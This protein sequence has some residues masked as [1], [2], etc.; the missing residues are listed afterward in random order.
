MRDILYLNAEDLEGLGLGLRRSVDI[1]EEAFRLKADGGAQMPPKIFF[2][3]RGD[4]FYSSMVSGAQ[5]LGFAAC[6][7]Q[8]G[9]PANP[10]RG[11]P[12]IQGLLILTDDETG[13]MLAV[14]DAK[15]ITGRRTAAASALVAR[16][17]ARSGV[18]ELAILG[19]GLQGRAHLRALAA[20]LPALEVCRVFDVARDVQERFVAEH[21]GRHAGI[22][23]VGCAGAEEALRGAEVI[24]TGGA[25]ESRRNA[26]IAPGWVSPGALIVT[27]DYDSYVTDECIAA[28]DIVMTDDR[29]QVEDARVN[30]GKFTGVE[31]LDT[32]L[33]ELVA[34]GRGRRGS[35]DQR[36]LS[37]NLGIALEDLATGAELYRL[38][39]EKGA[40]V[41]LRP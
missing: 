5:A 29:E 16:H 19:C 3:P 41:R 34:H 2:H 27:I 38:A 25:I 20:E 28:M 8:S 4:R 1:L 13:E 24:I 35:D 6:K 23:V 31:R 36:I 33:A 7:W 39:L 14:M 10:Q 18:R 9:N 32:D 21:D 12:Y 17:Q 26:T 15:W 40:G 37:F 11:L 30:E 22:R